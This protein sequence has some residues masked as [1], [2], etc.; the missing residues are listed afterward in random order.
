MGIGAH[1]TTAPRAPKS[2][3]S[4]CQRRAARLPAHVGRQPEWLGALVAEGVVELQRDDVGLTR[5][6]PEIDARQR[7]ALVAAVADAQYDA[8]KCV[9][10]EGEERPPAPVRPMHQQE[11]KPEDEEMVRVPKGLVVCAFDLLMCAGED[12]KHGEYEQLP[13]EARGGEARVRRRP[14]PRHLCGRRQVHMCAELEGVVWRGGVVGVV[15]NGMAE[16]ASEDEVF[17]ARLVARDEGVWSGNGRE[18]LRVGDA[19]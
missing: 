15:R 2:W 11:P 10:H 4:Q 1:S 8:I 17:G 14:A 9:R 12:D 13:R 7:H 16:R 5:L 3:G 19:T 6:A 18:R